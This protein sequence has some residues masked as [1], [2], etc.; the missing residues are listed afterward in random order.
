M[1]TETNYAE[2]FDNAN[3]WQ[4]LFKIAPP[5]MLALLIQALYNIVDSFFVGKYSGDGLTALSVIFPIQLVITAIAVGTGVG[6]NTLMAKYYA[7]RKDKE[8]DATAG[9]GMVLSVVSW[10]VFA[11]VSALIMKPYVCTSA[12]AAGAI[13]DAVSYGNIV[14]IGSIGIFLESNWS[15]VH[16]AGGN[17]KLPMIAQIAGA[18]TNILFDPLLIFGIGFFPEMGV[19]GAAYATVLGQ[20]VAAVITGSKGFCKIPEMKKLSHYIKMIYRYGYP[21][22]FM[23]LLYTVYI[24][25]LNVILAGFSDSAVTV[26][27]LYYKAQSLFF[28]PLFGLQTCIVPVL[29]Y[30]YANKS[31]RRCRDLMNFTC[32]ISA[33]FMIVGIIFFVFFPEALMSVFSKSEEVMQ[34]GS[35]AFPIIGSSFLPAVISLTMPVFF[36]AIG[37]GRTSLMLSLTRQV[38]CLIPIFRIFAEFGLNYTWFA[39]PISE[40]ISGTIGLIIYFSVLKKWKKETNKALSQKSVTE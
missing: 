9:T 39:Y 38:F 20:I 29:S 17:M 28:I 35:V 5:V 19:A 2:V 1:K 15:K 25:A 16:Q 32:L 37:Y 3:I 40:V 18:I 12:K 34:I 11:V 4:I 22:I 26:L 13:K 21:S 8:A 36:Q 7:G 33:A 31:Y 24:V 6:V 27:G 14:C 10:A 23:Q 30:N